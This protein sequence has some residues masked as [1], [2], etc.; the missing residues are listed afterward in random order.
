MAIIRGA[1]GADVLVVTA[2]NRRFMQ[3]DARMELHDVMVVC[4]FTAVGPDHRIPVADLRKALA[5]RHA[6]SRFL[7]AH[8]KGDVKEAW[9]ALAAGCT[10]SVCAEGAVGYGMADAIIPQEARLHD[11]EHVTF[12]RGR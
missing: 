12:H 3:A 11:A 5:A 8:T 7:S 6:V 2:C 4:S 9:D 1:R 10:I